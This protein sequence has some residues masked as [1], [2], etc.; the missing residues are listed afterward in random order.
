M[1]EQVALRYQAESLNERAEQA[2]QLEKQVEALRENLRKM[3]QRAFNAED[4][5]Q[6]VSWMYLYILDNSVH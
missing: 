2:E 4:A 5:L 1:D 6:Q 3:Q